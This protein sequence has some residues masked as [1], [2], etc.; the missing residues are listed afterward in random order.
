MKPSGSPRFH[1]STTQIGKRR[2]KSPQ[3][4]KSLDRYDLQK[5]ILAMKREEK[6]QNIGKSPKLYFNMKK[7]FDP[8][9][10]HHI[11]SERII[12]LPPKSNLAKGI[13]RYANEN[14][15][16]SLDRERQL[17][18]I[19]NRRNDCNDPGNDEEQDSRSDSGIKEYEWSDQDEKDNIKK[20]RWRH[21]YKGTSPP[22]I[23][24]NTQKKYDERN[25]FPQP[26]DEGQETLKIDR[27]DR[28]YDNDE[29]NA[30][31]TTQLAI[32]AA[33]QQ[34]I[35]LQKQTNALK[36]IGND[37]LLELKSTSN[38]LKLTVEDIKKNTHPKLLLFYKVRTYL[39][40]I[41]INSI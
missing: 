11:A 3:R 7:L 15:K 1:Y 32:D 23:N 31:R 14:A 22:I 5:E 39:L 16:R 6:L 37:K 21:Y 33:N 34:T 38:I 2:S 8:G 12:Q 41:H 25:I 35:V 27:N 4:K 17:Q 36:S 19:K 40:Y 29:S 18:I 9:Q 10:S 26:F 30:R 20:E 24:K 28:K 13:H